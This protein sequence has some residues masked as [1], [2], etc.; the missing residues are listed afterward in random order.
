MV[1]TQQKAP[2]SV[3]RMRLALVLVLVLLVSLMVRLVWIQG[4]DPANAAKAAVDARTTTQ[5]I[6]PVRGDIL[7][8]EGG[9]LATSIVRYDLVVDQ[10]Q[11]KATYTKRDPVTKKR[12]RVDA[13][14]DVKA[15]ADALGLDEEAVSLA[16]FG[17]EGAAKKGYSVITKSITPEAKDKAEDVGFPYLQAIQ[18]SQR[19]YPNGTLAGPVLGFMQTQLKESTDTAGNKSTEEVSAGV[20]GLELSQNDALSG[21]PGERVYEK[22]ADGVR[23]PSAP[24]T[25]TAAVDGQDVKLTIDSD[26]QWRAMEAVMAKQKEFKAEWVNAVV[27]EAKTGRILALADS[28][29]MDPNDPAAT[30]TRYR[31]STTV[32]QAFEPGSTGKVPTFALAL[33]QGAVSATSEFTVPNALKIGKETINDSLKHQKFEMT[34]AGVFARSYNTGT[35]QI[36]EKLSDQDR[37]DFMRKLGIGSKID[38]GLNGANAGLLANYSDWERRQRLTT[39]F[40]QGYTQ[41]AL[42]TAS[43]MQAIGNGGVQVA[44]KLIDS[45]IDPDG[46]VHKT[47]DSAT[48]RVVSEKTSATMRRMMET[49]VTD[50]TSTKMQI[51]GYRVG[52][53]SGTAQA[54]GDDGK[55]DQHT[56]SFAG[57]VPID[58]P[59]YIVVVTMQHPQGNWRS[60]TVGDTFTSIMKAVLAKNSVAPTTTEPNPFKVFVGENQNYGW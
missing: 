4:I 1:T 27:M 16:V 19:S 46:T 26:I 10:R 38:I 57:M 50:G 30:E 52:G 12:V 3:R 40:G 22:G 33:E 42:H 23:I 6:E 21:T 2:R 32:T 11:V 20:E 59:Q 48:Q 56:S 35:V 29:S 9:V 13:K 18:T 47:E 24:L 36:G 54:Q 31:S 41:T 49:V 14:D 7:D 44:P 17:K 8:S 25:E 58:D 15:L 53:K 39:M 37:Y 34:A 28:T 55:F 45:Y 43:I 60:W 51:A 5:V